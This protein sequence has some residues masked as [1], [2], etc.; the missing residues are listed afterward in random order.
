MCFDALQEAVAIVLDVGRGMTE[1]PP[2]E[3]S[4]LQVSLDAI[5]MILQRK[6]YNFNI[7]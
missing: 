4:R 6:V 1:V 7:R 2:G 3:Q 5:N